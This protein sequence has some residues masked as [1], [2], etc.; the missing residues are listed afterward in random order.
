MMKKIIF[1][2]IFVM[3]LSACSISLPSNNSSGNA[4]RTNVTNS[5]GKCNWGDSYTIPRADVRCTAG[6]VLN[7]L[8]DKLCVSG[9]TE[10]VRHTTE[11]MKNEAYSEYGIDSYKS[12][13]YEIDHL[14]PL[15]LG[16]ADTMNNLWP[17]P[18][19]QMYSNGY[20]LK[21]VEE[22]K[23]HNLVCNGS[24]TLKDAQQQI[25]REWTH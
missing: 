9:Y 11:K 19:D 7:V 6:E 25:I 16:G 13:Q 23:L 3:C 5:F 10:T 2:I 12:R 21:D 14:I 18:N 8:L 24:M 17:Q 20:Q 22:N 4:T 1:G 15:E